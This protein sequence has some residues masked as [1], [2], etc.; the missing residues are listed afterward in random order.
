MRSLRELD[1]L[2]ADFA[3]RKLQLTSGDEVLS[4][5]LDL[6]DRPAVLEEQE[7][8]GSVIDELRPRQMESDAGLP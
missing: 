7:K 6:A 3:Q 2:A 5:L 4:G 8:L 1:P